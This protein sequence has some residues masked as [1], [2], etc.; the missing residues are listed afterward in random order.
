M[1]IYH[2]KHIIE[3][4][5]NKVSKYMDL[6]AYNMYFVSQIDNLEILC[7]HPHGVVVFFL[8]F[9]VVL[10]HHAHKMEIAHPFL[11]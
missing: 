1:I 8:V 4:V 5:F 3:F 11:I 9:V 2:Q 10:F 7:T 6:V